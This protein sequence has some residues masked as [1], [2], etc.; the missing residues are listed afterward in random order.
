MR[1]AVECK[2]PLL[3]KS[4]ELFLGK[5]LSSIK[6]CDV[7]LRDIK[8]GDAKEIFVSSSDEA[9]LKKPFSKA[10][11]FLAIETKYANLGVVPSSTRDGLDFSILQ[12]RIESLTK[13]YQ[14][15][16]IKAVRVFYE[17]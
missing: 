12:R 11:L 3:Q 8:S 2:S 14:D 7:V 1:V 10:Q 16:I 5:N 9:I 13:E 6:N 4:L 15:N 17:S